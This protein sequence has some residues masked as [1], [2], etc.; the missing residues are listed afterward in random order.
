MYPM[1][2]KDM[3]YICMSCIAYAHEQLMTSDIDILGMYAEHPET[4]KEE[5]RSRLLNVYSQ[6]DEFVWGT[7]YR[8]IYR[9]ERKDFMEVKDGILNQ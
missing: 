5:N 9:D 4:W 3:I 8:C 7:P 1:F 6:L 2:V